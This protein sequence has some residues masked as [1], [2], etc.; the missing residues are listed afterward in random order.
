MAPANPEER[1]ECGSVTRELHNGDYGR[2]AGEREAAA[3]GS[4]A[5]SN[6]E[7]NSARVSLV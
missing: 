4:A 1:T 3:T 2:R 6:Q 7:I 5:S